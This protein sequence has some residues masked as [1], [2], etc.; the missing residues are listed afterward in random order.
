MSTRL[1]KY[2]TIGVMLKPVG[3]IFVRLLTMIAV[4][5]VLASLIVGAASLTDL[6]HIAKIGG[7]TLGFYALTAVVAIYYRACYCANLIQPGNKMDPSSKERLMD[8]YQDDA[9]SR[10]EQNVSMNIVDFLV[11][12]VPK[13][14]FQSNCRWRFSADSFLCDSD[15]SISCADTK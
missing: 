3:D 6:K 14:P 9:K 5:L 11:N 1:R 2:R 8:A 10:I 15:R 4:P 12:I 13:N 7:K